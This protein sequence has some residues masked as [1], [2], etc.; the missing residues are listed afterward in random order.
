MALIKFIF[1]LKKYAQLN[2]EFHIY[3]YVNKIIKTMYPEIFDGIKNI[4]AFYFDSNLKNN[5]SSTNIFGKNVFNP[6]KL[7][8]TNN[9][10]W[11]II[12]RSKFKYVF[13]FENGNIYRYMAINL[14]NGNF[15]ID[16][17]RHN[18]KKLYKIFIFSIFDHKK[19]VSVNRRSFMPNY[20]EFRNRYK[21]FQKLFNNSLNSKIDVNINEY[22]LLLNENNNN[23]AIAILPSATIQIRF[24]PPSLIE[25][26]ARLNKEKYHDIFIKDEHNYIYEEIAKNNSNIRIMNISNYKKMIYI[27]D[28]YKYKIFS[29]SGNF[30]V[31]CQNTTENNR[32]NFSCITMSTKIGNISKSYEYEGVNVFVFD[33]TLDFNWRKNWGKDN[34]WDKKYDWSN[35]EYS[36]IVLEK[37]KKIHTF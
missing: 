25:K 3:I 10:L 21:N 9:D 33:D 32:S 8:K 15:Y 7:K 30:H 36:K 29:D 19:M 14:I 2:P 18:L 20:D 23:E 34:I 37:F 28:K 5:M 17:S 27:V 16:D 31:F 24:I 26:I 35:V 11:R 1:T 4:H 12:L 6:Y 13:S 22:S